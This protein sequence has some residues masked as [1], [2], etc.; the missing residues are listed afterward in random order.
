MTGGLGNDSLTGGDGADYFKFNT[1]LGKTNIDYIYSFAHDTDRIQL[2]DAIF[3]KFVGTNGQI[4]SASFVTGDN[5]V[6]ALDTNDFLIFNTATGAL[7]YDADGSGKG[8]A[9]QFA[10]LVGVTDLAAS[11]F[12]IV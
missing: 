1:A 7:S 10:T 2:D 8:A 5:G 9:M 3:K 11:D 6:K 4:D 12:W